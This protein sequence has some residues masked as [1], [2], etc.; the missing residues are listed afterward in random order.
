MIIIQRLNKIKRHH[1]INKISLCAPARK[2]WEQRGHKVNQEGAHYGITIYSFKTRAHQKLSPRG[3]G[4][5]FKKKVDMNTTSP[6]N[7]HAQHVLV[8]LWVVDK[9]CSSHL[10]VQLAL[11]CVGI[12]TQWALLLL[13]YCASA[14]ARS[15]C[16]KDN[17][18]HLWVSQGVLYS[19]VRVQAQNNGTGDCDK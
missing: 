1:A 8:D 4:I 6:V 2:K 13:D 7:Q 3:L 16:T 10:S 15:G 14:G 5:N 9:Q 12:E 11:C 19:S 17:C 18:M